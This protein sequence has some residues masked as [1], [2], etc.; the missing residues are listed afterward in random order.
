MVGER[1]TAARVESL[2][3]AVVS[4]RG[5]RGECPLVANLG[6]NGAVQIR[7]VVVV[8]PNA[9]TV[10]LGDTAFAGSEL[11]VANDLRSISCFDVQLTSVLCNGAVVGRALGQDVYGQEGL[12]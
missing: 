5:S 6:G 9:A 8:G 3:A 10:F 7:L 2:L 11:V 1:R 12:E 4:I